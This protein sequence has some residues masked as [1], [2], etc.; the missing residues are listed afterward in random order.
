MSS[1][2]PSLETK[3]TT[4]D[5]FVKLFNRTP[6][7]LANERKL[8]REQLLITPEWQLAKAAHDNTKKPRFATISQAFECL[9]S[10][11]VDNWMTE[12]KST[13]SELERTPEYNASYRLFLSEMSRVCGRNSIE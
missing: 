7:S 12:H 11:S 13:R 2:T 3:T 8:T 6:S 5:M 10:S 1:D 9:Y 4:A